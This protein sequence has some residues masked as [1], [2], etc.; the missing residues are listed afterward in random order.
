MSDLTRRRFLTGAPVL[1]AAVVIGVAVAP[2]AV[3]WARPK[4]TTVP[5]GPWR[6]GLPGDPLP[7]NLPLVPKE[8]HIGLD[9]DSKGQA[10]PEAIPPS[11]MNESVRD[12]EA[13]I[14][15]HYRRLVDGGTISVQRAK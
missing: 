10:A 4:L 8:P 13:I 5:F 9:E 6:L 14:S 2:L 1:A 15:R 11:Q 12:T 7:V 3:A